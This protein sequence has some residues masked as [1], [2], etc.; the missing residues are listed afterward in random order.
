MKNKWMVALFAGMLLMAC[1]GEEAD[2][3]QEKEEPIEEVSADAETTVVDEDNPSHL[4]KEGTYQADE[5]GWGLPAD[6]NAKFIEITTKMQ[7]SLQEHEDWSREMISNL[8]EGEPMPYDEKLGIT[9]EEYD[10]IINTDDHLQMNKVGESEVTITKTEEGLTIE[11][12]S[13]KLMKKITFNADGSVAQIDADELSYD[14]E[15]VASDEQ[16]LTGK[17]NGHTYQRKQENPQKIIEFSF[18]K[19]E[20]NGKTIFYIKSVDESQ[21]MKDEVLIF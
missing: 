9:K 5:M 20:E 10:F 7:A 16:N 3:E 2:K 15:V 4:L 1:G 19:L 14:R 18:G 6:M 12:P 13:S 11:I 21:G 17:W 8:E